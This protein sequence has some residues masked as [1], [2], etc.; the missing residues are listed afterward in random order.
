MQCNNSGWQISKI[1]EEYADR[2]MTTFSVVP[3]PKVSHETETERPT[4]G[5]KERTDG[6]SDGKTYID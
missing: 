6:Q 4:D 1:R 3:S 2:I 5:M